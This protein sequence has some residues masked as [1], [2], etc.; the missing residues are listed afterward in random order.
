MKLSRTLWTKLSVIGLGAVLSL[1]VGLSA[2]TVSQEVQAA[3]PQTTT[4]SAIATKN[5]WVNGTNTHIYR[6]CFYFFRFRWS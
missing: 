5:G 4:I 6:W 3:S 2:R 1:G